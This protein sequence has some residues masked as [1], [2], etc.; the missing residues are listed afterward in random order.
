MNFNSGDL[1]IRGFVEVWHTRRIAEIWAFSQFLG[2]H[3]GKV[4]SAPQVVR[5][6]KFYV[7]KS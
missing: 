2:T 6:S 7:V 5:K 3:F 4:L 1:L